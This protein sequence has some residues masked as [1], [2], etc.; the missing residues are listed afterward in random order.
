MHR[1]DHS[2]A[3]PR[4]SMPISFQQPV[5]SFAVFAH[6]T[7]QTANSQLGTEASGDG[8]DLNP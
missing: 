3:V 6:S 7:A 5:R 2:L 4:A 8:T 1:R